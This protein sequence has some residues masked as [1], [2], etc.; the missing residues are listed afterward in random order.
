MGHNAKY[1]VIA[2]FFLQI[3]DCLF[4][5]WLPQTASRERHQL[6]L[7]RVRFVRTDEP[8][9]GLNS[10]DVDKRTT[11]NRWY[12]AEIP[13][14]ANLQKWPT[15]IWLSSQDAISRGNRTH[16]TSWLL[17]NTLIYYQRRPASGIKAFQ[18]RISSDHDE[19]ILGFIISA[20]RIG[21]NRM[22]LTG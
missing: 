8:E 1:F 12:S 21:A 22:N 3:D 19:A 10:A 6:H 13:K 9:D 11:R 7:F 17:I 16:S 2:R 18:W 15:S 5:P 14:R 20:R 4:R